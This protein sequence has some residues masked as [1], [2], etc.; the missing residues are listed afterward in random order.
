MDE[1][2][3]RIEAQE[4]AQRAAASRGYPNLDYRCW[5]CGREYSRE[6]SLSINEW[7]EWEAAGR[8]RMSKTCDDCHSPDKDEEEDT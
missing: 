5:E 1:L 3:R 8:R 7:L 6:S 4:A 2:T